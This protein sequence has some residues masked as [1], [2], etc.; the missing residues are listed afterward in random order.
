[1]RRFKL[2]LVA[3]VVS[4]FTAAVVT[5]RIANSQ[6]GSKKPSPPDATT[7]ATQ[8]TSKQPTGQANVAGPRL[9]EEQ[10]P[11]DPEDCNNC[12]VDPVIGT[13]APTGFDNEPNDLVDQATHDDDRATF[14]D[15]RRNPAERHAGRRPRPRLQRASLLR[16]SPESD[17]RL[18]QAD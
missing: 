5:N 17:L 6:N 18:G 16:V 1:M 15:A 11:I 2:L 7:T 3:A 8:N 4:L 14:F 9:T 10:C 12:Q 13:E